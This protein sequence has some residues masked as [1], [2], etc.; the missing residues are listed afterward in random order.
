[1]GGVNLHA[2]SPNAF[3]GHHEAVAQAVGPDAALTVANADLS[4]QT[5][6]QAMEHLSGFAPAG[7]AR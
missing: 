3:E 4:F 6:K 5:R 2:S 1:M 7:C